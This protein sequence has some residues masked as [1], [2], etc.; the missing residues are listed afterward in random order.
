MKVVHF[1]PIYL[2]NWGYQENILP[3]Y[4]KTMGHETYVITPDR[5]PKQYRRFDGFKKK[6]YINGV[7]IRRINILVYITFTFFI[8]KGLYK[9]IKELKPDILFHHGIGLNSLL[10]C[11][12]YK[13][14]HPKC[15]LFVDNHT[16]EINQSQSKIWL[17]FYSKIVLAIISNLLS[18]FVIF[19]YG[20]SYSRCDYLKSVFRLNCRK[21]KFLP[22]GADTLAVEKIKVSDQNVRNKYFIDKNEFIVISGGKIGQEKGTDLLI[23]A[24]GELIN[25]NMRIRLVLFGSFI[26][27]YTKELAAKSSFVT[28]IG[29]CD[30]L[31]TMQLLRMANVAVWPI[32][33]TTLIE[34]SI[35]CLTPL[36]IRKTRTTE[37]LIKGNGVFITHGSQIELKNAILNI[38]EI[39]SSELELNCLAIRNE[40]DYRTIA[41]TIIEDSK[42]VTT[43]K[44]NL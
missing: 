3:Q 36:I 4:F 30:R 22:I 17:L 43:N 24:V 38:F 8:T 26:D 33:H 23:S 19:F 5:Y 32:H 7:E 25:E 29:W 31:T 16:D 41:N 15:A 37:H 9:N 10:V 12:F 35:A 2:D 39:D 40:I 21:I 20:V 6:Y 13:I 34:D 28:V 27:D 44:I 14:L 18:P 11:G 1:C 42:R